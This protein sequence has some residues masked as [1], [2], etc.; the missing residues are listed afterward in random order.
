L[1]SLGR[2]SRR[3]TWYPWLYFLGITAA[4]TLI[5]LGRTWPGVILHVV[6]LILLIVQAALSDDGR[7]YL[8]LILAPLIRLLSLVL[9]MS[10]IPMIFR[11]F[12]VSVPL[13]LAAFSVARL[14]GYRLR[15]IALSPGRWYIQLAIAL[16]GLPMGTIEYLILRPQALVPAFQ[17]TGL[18]VPTLVLLVSTG[19]LEEL[20]FRGIIQKAAT[21]LMRRGGAILFVSLLFAAM[22]ITHQSWPDLVYVFLVALFF[23]WAVF[24]TRSLTG[25]TLAHGL[26]NI[27]LYLV[28]PFFPLNLDQ[29]WLWLKGMF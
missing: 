7:F 27:I 23:G 3:G 5:A 13:F 11:Y 8:A 24:R 12:A 17:A 28:L 2:E 19:F 21:D 20:I 18:V 9:P 22:H 16:V 1:D 26:N 15:D 4:E 10:N 14:S 25:V 6:M 29:M